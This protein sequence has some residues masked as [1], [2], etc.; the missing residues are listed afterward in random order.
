[1]Y[2]EVLFVTDLAG[3]S[4]RTASIWRCSR[5]AMLSPAQTNLTSTTALSLMVHFMCICGLT[6]LQWPPRAR[7]RQVHETVGCPIPCFSVQKGARECPLC[8]C[9]AP[10]IRTS[11]EP[12]LG[13]A[14]QQTSTRQSKRHYL[15]KVRT[16]CHLGQ[17]LHSS[18]LNPMHEPSCTP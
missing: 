7:V 15:M 8:G 13:R 10:L 17:G 16:Q 1:M 4:I 14:P 6:D 2:Q 18:L 3:N 9:Y 11:A 12:E 5:K